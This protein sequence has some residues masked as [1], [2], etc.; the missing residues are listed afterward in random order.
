MKVALLIPSTS[1]G[2]DWKTFQETY[3]F[4]HTVKTFLL[5]YNKEHEYKFFIGIDENDPIYDNEEVKTQIQRFISIMKN[6]EIE[7]IYMTNIPKG[8][9]TVMW[10]RLYDEALGQNYEYFFQCGDDIEFHTSNWVNDCILTLE[11]TKGVGLVGPINNNP[12]ILTQS[13]VSRKHKDIFG[14]FFPPEIINWFCDDWINEVYK[15]IGHFYPLNNH[16]CNNIGGQPR[17]EINNESDFRNDIQ[18]NMQR[19]REQCMSIVNKD[20]IKFKRYKTK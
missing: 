8:H 4:K 1:K 9:L 20:Y 11:K 7:F 3:L 12:R 17:Y 18:K 14:Y 5:T 6:V 13:F 15:K 16:F 10:N 19:V 2:R